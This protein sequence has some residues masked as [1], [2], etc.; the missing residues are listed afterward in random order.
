MATA[1]GLFDTGLGLYDR[2]QD[3]L[4]PN[5][6]P[7]FAT[8]QISVGNFATS[9]D[10]DRSLGGDAPGVSVFDGV[11]SYCGTEAGH[12][13]NDIEGTVHIDRGTSREYSIST[14]LHA[15]Y[16]SVVAGGT[17]GVCIHSVTMSV[18]GLSYA[19]TGDVGK[20]CG[21][22][23]YPQSNPIDTASNVPVCIWI[24]TNGDDGHIWKGFNIHLPSFSAPTEIQSKRLDQW[25]DNRDLMCK[26]EPRFSMYKD[27]SLDNQIRVFDGPYNP[28]Q[29]GVDNATQILDAGAW[30]LSEVPHNPH[31]RLCAEKGGTCPPGGASALEDL[32]EKANPSRRA[33]RNHVKRQ[34]WMVEQLVVSNLESHSA[35]ELCESGT[36][37]GPDFVSM[38]EGLFCDMSEKQVWPLCS[39][40]TAGYC[41]DM[42]SQTIRGSS[43]STSTN[44][45]VPYS[46]SSVTGVSKFGSSGIPLKSY[47][48]TQTWG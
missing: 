3:F 31:E 5:E 39:D 8:V 35:T 7:R 6:K 4:F 45:K 43:I 1:I 48:R 32:K 44:S 22:E 29:E 9:N 41:F 19:W 11:G 37:N 23:W 10:A 30:K 25:K 2:L 18:N 14:N 15:E 27:I 34:A 40:T 33:R 26:S 47:T 12:T 21:A 28:S 46:N 24:D 16:I 38:A 36:S 17:N 42:D 20:A 13:K